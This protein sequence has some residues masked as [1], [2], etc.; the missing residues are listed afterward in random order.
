MIRLIGTVLA[1]TAGAVLVDVAIAGDTHM[2]VP[3][4]STAAEL[5]ALS[6]RSNVVADV[7]TVDRKDYVLTLD[8]SGGGAFSGAGLDAERAAAG[9]A[10]SPIRIPFEQMALVYYVEFPVDKKDDT[11]RYPAW[12]SYPSIAAIGAAE[13]YMD[14]SEL[15]TEIARAGTVRWYARQHG[16]VPFTEHEA[17]AQHGKNA[18]KDV[19]LGLLVA[20]AL[21]GAAGG[22]PFGGSF[23]GGHP[24][25]SPID[26]ETFRWAVTAA[27]RREVAL[28][29]LKRERLCAASAT[30]RG[31]NTDLEILTKIEATRQAL[32]TKAISDQEQMRQQ[33]QLLDQFDPEGGGAHIVA[34]AALE[35]FDFDKRADAKA[36]RMFA[37]YDGLQIHEPRNTACSYSDLAPARIGAPFQIRE[38][39]LIWLNSS[40]RQLESFPLEDIQ[41]VRP[42]ERHY[43]IWF[44]PIKKPNG[45]CAFLALWPQLK[46]DDLETVRSKIIDCI[47]HC[48]NAP[49]ET[50]DKDQIKQ[51]TQLLDQFNGRV[52][53]AAELA[54]GLAK[55]V[56]PVDEGAVTS[57]P[58]VTWFARVNAWASFLSFPDAAAHALHGTLA[59]T[60]QSL[61]FLSGSDQGS[62]NR[63]G[64]R[65]P[66]R[67]IQA[68]E[69]RGVLRNRGVVITRRDGHLD[70]F[71]IVHGI[72]IDPGQTVARGELLR[73]K[74]QAQAATPT[75]PQ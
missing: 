29:Q 60:D 59:V 74:V 15:D 43:F 2:V 62:T 13:R 42:L 34:T 6:R 72:V 31:E 75:S 56:I 58:D 36:G 45:S 33:T 39:G 65:I 70:S 25:P 46:K 23:G 3:S 48:A 21:V 61:T 19:G 69:I 32:A 20:M 41:E 51:Q 4:R 38:R 55:V 26:Q 53:T 5:D 52:A 47:A 54:A 40:S 24:P 14:C 67:E 10:R 49:P 63:I 50:S 28:L 7:L 12:A 9:A 37:V 17:L 27:D 66:Y 73:S 18:A 68:V 16:V 57:Y 1:L 35:A 8:G 64:I 71:Q 30:V 22:G 11:F 44:I